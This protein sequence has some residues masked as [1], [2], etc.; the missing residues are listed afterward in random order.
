MNKILKLVLLFLL[1]NF[2]SA[3]ASSG[4]FWLSL[5]T[6]SENFMTAQTNTLGSR[7]YFDS[8]PTVFAGLSIPFMGAT[9]APGIG[10]AMVLDEKDSTT[11]THFI[12]KGHMISPLTSNIYLHYG[13][14]TMLTKIGG[15]GGTL[16]LNDGN[17]TS[18]M[19]VPD[20]TK[21][22][23]TS[24]LDFGFDFLLTSDWSFRTEVFITRFLSSERRKVNH[25][26]SAVWFL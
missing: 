7:N 1:L 8:T 15:K 14:S 13:M 3:W 16:T 20:T 5:G 10:Y 11:K 2:Q 21:V 24:S 22:S 23:Y 4:N 26:I 12:F 17:A 19:Y 18:T 9:L 25:L 6:L